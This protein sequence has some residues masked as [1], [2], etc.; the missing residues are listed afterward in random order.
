MR[1]RAT[2]ERELRLLATVRN[3]YREHGK[4]PPSI[5]LVDALLDELSELPPA[6]P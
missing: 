4:V 1:D 2:I 5:G 6:R 3:A